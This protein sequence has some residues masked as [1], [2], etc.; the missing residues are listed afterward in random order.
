MRRCGIAS[1]PANSCQAPIAEGTWKCRLL[2][3]RRPLAWRGHPSQ[4]PLCSAAPTPR[5]LQQQS[6]APPQHHEVIIRSARDRTVANGRSALLPF[7]R[8]PGGLAVHRCGIASAPAGVPGTHS[9]RNLEVQA[10]PPTP[11]SGMAW[12]PLAGVTLSG[13]THSSQATAAEHCSTTA[14]PRINSV[15]FARMLM[16][17]AAYGCCN[18]VSFV[19]M[20]LTAEFRYNVV[21]FTLIFLF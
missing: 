6:T 3:P 5:R 20:F 8:A 10:P 16:F 11:P 21:S 7:R 18:F 15:S 12:T 1:A 2:R 13:S 14:A 4:A 17:L 9:W 19:L